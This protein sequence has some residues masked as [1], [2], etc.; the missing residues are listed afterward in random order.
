MKNRT[1]GES[2]ET[3]DRK[4]FFHSFFS[5]RGEAIDE[6]V[7]ISAESKEIIT[8]HSKDRFKPN[9]LVCIQSEIA[10]NEKTLSD[11]KMEIDNCEIIIS[12]YTKYKP[13]K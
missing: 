7:A 5:S 12:K 6:S 10:A 4:A 13:Q 2:Q 8:A 1:F 11:L 3:K 9:E